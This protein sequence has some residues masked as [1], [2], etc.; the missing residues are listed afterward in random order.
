VDI[1]KISQDILRDLYGASRRLSMYPL[2]HPITQETLRKPLEFLNHI[3]LIKHSFNIEYHKERLVAEGILL[4]DTVYVSGLALDME[5]HKLSNMAIYSHVQIGNLYHF[6]SELI[7][8][9]D[10]RSE[11]LAEI[12][13]ARGIDAVAVNVAQTRNIFRFDSAERTADQ[14]ARSLDKR[15]KDIISG[16]PSIIAAYYMGKINNDDDVLKYIE[17]DF[18]LGF[19][20]KYIKES[21]LIMDNESA[22][23]LLE[24]IVFTTNWLD[25]SLDS[26]AINGLKRLFGDYLF[27]QEDNRALTDIYRLFKKVGAPENVI[28][29]IFDRS[30][31]LKLKTFQDSEEIV[32]TLRFS[33]PSQIDSEYLKKTVFKLASAGQKEYLFDIINQLIDS[34]SGATRNVRQQALQ[35][36]TIGG[37]VISGG[38]FYDEFGSLCRTA[39]KLALMPDD[40]LEPAE[41]TSNLAWQALRKKR[42]QELKFL[43]RMEAGITSDRMQ[44]ES[45]RD[46][47]SKRLLELREST[48]LFET[49]NGMLGSDWD[50][51]TGGFFE[52]IANLGSKKIIT[53]LVEKIT[54]PDTN[55]RSRII[56]ILVSM[57]ESSAEVLS[58]FL[59]EEVEKYK[60]G[61]LEDDK[62]YLLR[63]ILRV[64]REVSAE[65]SLPSLEIMSGWQ[66]SRLKIEIIRTLEGMSAAA[67]AKLLQR[68][69][70]DDDFEIKKAA[71]TAM[72]LTGHPDMIPKLNA[73]IRSLPE[74]RVL[75]V[76][77]LGRIGGSKSRDFLIDLF[78]NDE[79]QQALSL[80]NKEAEEI[81]V[82]IL[83]AL[84]RIGDKKSLA[85]I[86][87]YSQKKF[88][89]SLFKK[90]L[91]SNT[92]KIIL[93]AKGR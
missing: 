83:K 72:G 55:L 35:L 86:E 15:I 57:K 53:S 24:D 42:W 60:G 46:F 54:S 31:A 88:N 79:L 78:E 21:L 41:L 4:D 66:D 48:L 49:V 84:A 38:G 56:K 12:L 80:S 9:P 14:S 61:K 39:V 92:A 50:E 10:P 58:Q 43:V 74:C 36:L 51:D 40:I 87:E 8:K 77:S 73:I 89:K 67:S 26:R 85:K 45:K 65:E 16:N 18:R 76:A 22:V 63:N 25:D 1:K 29:Q 59:A 28:N 91:L 81:R 5:K 13:S 34:I 93:D 17:A 2:G 20:S 52:A 30:N 82:A 11:G 70:D 33:D 23:K 69:C 64:L 6:L 62:W 3:F 44:P 68:F 27:H 37:E 75:A 47:V 7:A 32:N 71:V 19:V 90:D